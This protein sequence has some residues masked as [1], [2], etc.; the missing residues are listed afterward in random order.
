MDKI[1]NYEDIEINIEGYAYG[2][3]GTVFHIGENTGVLKNKLFVNNVKFN[4][5]TPNQVKKLAS[6]KGNADKDVMYN[7]F[8]T[9]T[10]IDLRV[11]LDYDSK[12]IGS[13]IG[14]IVDSYYLCKSLI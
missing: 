9:E 7:A 6:G 13:P 1:K 8:L 2:A 10:S 4:T 11:A 5:I 14:D 3:K 12:N